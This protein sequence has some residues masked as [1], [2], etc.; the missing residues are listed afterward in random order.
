MLFR[1]IEMMFYMVRFHYFLFLVGTLNSSCI[2]SLPYINITKYHVD[3]FG[4]Y[5]FW[6]NYENSRTG[7]TCIHSSQFPTSV[8]VSDFSWV[9]VLGKDWTSLGEP[10][11]IWLVYF[12]PFFSYVCIFGTVF[13]NSF[14]VKSVIRKLESPENGEIKWLSTWGCTQ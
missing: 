7:Y 13:G 11:E 9:S 14:A 1:T 8:S 10:F 3:I 2:V 5:L 4:L 12:E 6:Y